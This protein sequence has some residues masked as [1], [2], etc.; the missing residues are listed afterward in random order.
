MPLDVG[1][2]QL[3]EEVSEVLEWIQSVGLGCLDDAVDCGTGFGSFRGIAEQPVLAADC[4]VADGALADVVGQ[5]GVAVLQERLQLFLMREGILDGLAELGFRQD[6]GH[7]ILKPCEISLEL[8]FLKL[9]TLVLP[10]CSRE[11]CQFFVDGK[12]CI[13]PL[14]GFLADAAEEVFF[15]EVRR[16]SLHE[17]PPCMCPAECMSTAWHFLV[18]G[19]AVRLQ[20]AVESLEEGFCIAVAAAGLVF[21]EADGMRLLV[22]AATEDPYVRFRRVPATLLFVDL[23]GRLI[24]MD[25][26]LLQ[27]ILLQARDERHEPVLGGPD[28]PV[29]QGCARE[30]DADLFPLPFLPVER[31]G[32]QVLLHHD[33]RDARRRGDGLSDDGLRGG[34][35]G[36]VAMARW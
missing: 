6:F 19:V 5:C 28:N 7:D 10:L 35:C 36:P 22:L 32:L 15:F 25:D 27:E 1:I 16:D 34:P 17:V 11:S 9:E 4:E 20:D 29:C 13:D 8:V 2:R 21:V 18:A 31:H 12:E 30:R 14:N 23:H 33:M 26:I 3:L 24:C